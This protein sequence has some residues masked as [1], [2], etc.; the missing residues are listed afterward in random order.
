MKPTELI[1][2]LDV[3]TVEMIPTV[4]DAL[5]D[6]VTFYK[7]GLELFIAGGPAALRPLTE[8]G[9]KIFLD[10]KLHDI[11]R[12]VARAVR[13]AAAHQVSLLTV[14]GMGGRDMLTAAAEAAQTFGSDAPELLAIT[15]LTSLNQ[16]DLSEL[17]I[18]RDL[19]PHTHAIG[20]LAIDCGID[21]LVCSP[22]EVG[23]FRSDL[24]PEVSLVTPGI[25]PAGSDVGDQKRVATPASAI[26]EGASYLVVGRPIL[27][28]QDPSAAARQILE[29]I[30][31]AN[32]AKRA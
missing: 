15:T 7:V 25:R 1:V 24:G 28:A 10:L 26:A 6:E 9:K 20:K 19:A 21:G 18:S 23:A 2:A 16:A 31:E 27:Q 4:V 32:Q 17:G 3:P 11:P 14:H 30:E 13:T 5:P 8:R 12:T 29:Q 22:L